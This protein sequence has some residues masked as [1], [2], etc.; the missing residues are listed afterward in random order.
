[1]DFLLILLAIGGLVVAGVMLLLASRASRMER[2]S[3]ERVQTLQALATGS[4]LFAAEPFDEFTSAPLAS[5]TVAEFTSM[6]SATDAF[7][8]FDD[9]RIDSPSTLGAD[10]APP[11]VPSATFERPANAYPF[12]MTVPEGARRILGSF[13]RAQQGSRT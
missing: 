12:V 6:P 2:E 1:M 7:D 8:E 4:V 5:D 9:E 13:D 10:D 3:D 11:V